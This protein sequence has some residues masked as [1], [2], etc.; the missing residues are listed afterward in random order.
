MQK[1]DPEFATGCES[2]GYTSVAIVLAESG[3]YRWKT[4]RPSMFWVRIVR[5]ARRACSMIGSAAW[6][7]AASD[8]N[9]HYIVLI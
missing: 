4:C 7:N 2:G 6:V 9:V 8:H 1:L 5:K 3:C